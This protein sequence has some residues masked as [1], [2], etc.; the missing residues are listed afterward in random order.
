MK[1]GGGTLLL[2]LLTLQAQEVPR[3]ERWELHTSLR[4][5]RA[6]AP[7]SQ[8][9]WAATSGGLFAY[10]RRSGELRPLRRTEGLLVQ[11]LTAVAVDGRSGVV[12]AG[13]FDGILEVSLPDGSWKHVV[14]IAI[15]PGLPQRRINSI[16]IEQGRAYVGTA[17]GIV[18][19]DLATQTILAS[20]R[21]I[22]TLPLNTPVASLLLWQDSLWVGTA[23]G[24]WVA[25]RVQRAD[26]LRLPQ[27]WRQI[28]ELDSI[29]ALQVLPEGIL[30]VTARTVQ[31]YSQGQLRA[32]LEAPAPLVGAVRTASGALYWASA[33]ELWQEYPQRRPVELP[34]QATITELRWAPWEDAEGWV[35]VGLEGQGVAMVRQGD[36]QRL[37]QPNTPHTNVLTDCALTDEGELWCATDRTEAGRGLARYEH[38]SWQAYV[39]EQLPE[40]GSNGYHR[41]LARG[42]ELW[43]ANW[44]RGLLRIVPTD[45]GVQLQRFDTAAGIVGIPADPRFVPIGGLALDGEG[46]LWAVCHWCGTAALLRW[47]E[48]EGVRP[49][50]TTLPLEQRRNNALL[51]DRF[52]TKWLGSLVG[53]GLFYFREAQ[54]TAGEVLGR[55]TTSTTA[56]PSNI[57]YALAQDR[58]GMLWVGTPAGVGVVLNPE[59]VL[60]GTQPVVRNVSLLREQAVYAI[61][62]DVADNKW[63]ATDSGI[64]IVTPDATAVLLRLTTQNSPL[65]S[66]E[67]RSLFIEHRSGRV[68]VGTRAGVAI[69]WS[70]MRAPASVPAIECFPQPFLPERDQLLTIDGL[71]ERSAVRILTLEGLQVRA[72]QTESRTAYWDGRND[73]GELVPAGVYIVTATSLTSGQTAQ[74]KVLLVRP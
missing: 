34:L 19:L 48:R 6:I 4:S 53:D 43:A 8:G 21:R 36:F 58:E 2:A 74:A 22:G 65:P 35:L 44:G 40:L 30:I 29:R 20:L 46:A 18:V 64:W 37:L 66:D 23:Q 42:R 13:S 54:G 14:D 28:G 71:G 51:V 62:V 17:F 9:F 57:I 68:Y 38:G 39:V 61:A 45:T 3:I 59:A 25:P 50:L 49:F 67:V 69:L 33:R 24:V 26:S 5:I 73:Q 31:E 41:V 56:L 72:F 32:V 63:L 27:L 55:L 15:E 52:G 60:W 11:D 47:S 70:S 10:E 12:V 16:A 1:W 7:D